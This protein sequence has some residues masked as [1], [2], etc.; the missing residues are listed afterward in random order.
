M[1]PLADKLAP[2]SED[3]CWKLSGAATVS[4][5][6]H[7][8]VWSRSMPNVLI[9]GYGNRMRTDDAVGA[10]AADRL[11]ESYRDDPRV[12][13]MS[14]HQLMPE[15]AS[16]IA[17]AEFLLLLD[18]DAGGVPGAITK[19][20]VTARADECSFTHNCTPAALLFAARSLYGHTPKAVSLTLAAASFDVG[21]GLSPTASRRLP[22]FLEAARQIVSAWQARVVAPGGYHKTTS[23]K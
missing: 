10:E 12:R 18:A 23:N 3:R 14:S 9:I 6:A 1:Q 15:M 22:D 21:M 19:T 8:E 2:P 11:A 17:E 20:V 7:E 4:K 13:V 16:D 5:R